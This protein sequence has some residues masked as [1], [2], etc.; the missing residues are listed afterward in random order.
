MSE[1]FREEDVLEC[2]EYWTSPKGRYKLL[3]VPGE[4]DD[5]Q[6]LPYDTKFDV[7]IVIEKEAVAR[8]VIR[9][10]QAAGIEEINAVPGC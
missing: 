10:M 4:E 3:K 8:E 9:R 6:F 2:E 7:A 5:L 1:P